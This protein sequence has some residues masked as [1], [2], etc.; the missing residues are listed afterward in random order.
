MKTRFKTNSRVKGYAYHPERIL[1][2]VFL[3]FT[4]SPSRKRHT[5]TIWSREND[6]FGLNLAIL[7]KKTYLDDHLQNVQIRLRPK[8]FII[9]HDC[10]RNERYQ[11][12]K[13]NPATDENLPICSIKKNKFQSK[14]NHRQW[15]NSSLNYTIPRQFITIR[16]CP[17]V[18]RYFRNILI[19]ADDVYTHIWSSHDPF[20]AAAVAAAV[21]A[22]YARPWT[23]GHALRLAS[24]Y[25]VLIWRPLPHL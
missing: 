9:Y 8:R 22:R 6:S 1:D 16:Q 11:F 25:L 3:P 18:P 4:A 2:D 24:V 7:R 17:L 15:A 13:S 21:G 23:L 10:T 20:A 5:S 12:R 14:C 19:S